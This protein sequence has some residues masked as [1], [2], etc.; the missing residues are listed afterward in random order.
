[1]QQCPQMYHTYNIRFDDYLLKLLDLANKMTCRA[2][3]H[4]CVLLWS[5]AFRARPGTAA[6]GGV[7][8]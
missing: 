4:A 6:S 1:M 8:L 7:A 5:A 3:I 2:R